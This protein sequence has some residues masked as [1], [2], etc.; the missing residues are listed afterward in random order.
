MATLP[1]LSEDEL[2]LLHLVRWMELAYKEEVFV[3][4]I[5]FETGGVWLY[6]EHGKTQKFRTELFDIM[7]RVYEQVPIWREC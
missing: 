4:D 5:D 6:G 7:T 2:S 3:M 1:D